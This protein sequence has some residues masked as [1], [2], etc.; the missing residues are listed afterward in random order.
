MSVELTYYPKNASERDLD[1]HLREF[2]FTRNEDSLVP[3]SVDYGWFETEDYKSFVGVEATIFTPETNG[4]HGDCE[5]ALH[6]RTRAGASFADRDCQN[7]I[8]RAARKKFGGSF[9]NDW[10]GKNRYIPLD[11]DRRDTAARGIFISYQV[12]T[13]RIRAV[14]YALPDPTESLERL[15]GTD[16]EYLSTIDPVRVLYNALVPFAV[17]ALEHFFCQSFKILLKY[18]PEAQLKLKEQSRKIEMPQVIAI[19]DG[20]ESVEDAVADW[21][22]FQN[23]ASIHKAFHEWFAIDFWKLLRRRRKIG[24]RLPMLEKQL[25]SVIGFRHS[26]IHRFEL[27]QMLRKDEI[28]EIFDLVLVLIRLR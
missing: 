21:Y 22:S 6:T 15:V 2:E 28:N 3:D 10:N 12:V 25:N 27:D 14:K 1:Q 23:I 7:R 19:R 4:P 26:V 18:D 16:L 20:A 17:A 5:V 13:E 9:Y 24:R 11:P 8:I